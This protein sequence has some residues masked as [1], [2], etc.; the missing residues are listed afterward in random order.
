MAAYASKPQVLNAKSSWAFCPTAACRRIGG[1]GESETVRF[2]RGRIARLP[3]LIREPLGSPRT[4]DLPL[5]YFF[6]TCM[7]SGTIR[8]CA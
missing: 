4:Q 7:D 5:R 6:R 3:G 1:D 8:T 2:G